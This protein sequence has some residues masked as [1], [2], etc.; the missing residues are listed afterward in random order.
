[1]VIERMTPF[2]IRMLNRQS[3]LSEGVLMLSHAIRRLTAWGMTAS[4]KLSSSMNPVSSQ[5]STSPPWP[6]SL[7]GLVL[8]TGPRH[9]TGLAITLYTTHT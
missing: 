4:Y 8:G 7:D 2:F 1:M 5:M 9:Q 6:R 3:G